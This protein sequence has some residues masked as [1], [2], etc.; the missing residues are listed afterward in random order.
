MIYI[1]ETIG[2]HVKELANNMREDDLTEAIEKYGM[3][4]H[5]MLFDS[6]A[7]SDVCFSI[8]NDEKLIAIMGIVVNSAG[9]QLWMIFNKNIDGL[10]YSFY[11]KANTVIEELQSVYGELYIMTNKKN[12]QIIK[13]AKMLGFSENITC[14]EITCLTKSC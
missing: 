12:I 1:E 2:K 8:Y 14:Y 3:T 13:L 7:Y 4:G 10:P 9:N 5:K 6:C 11:K